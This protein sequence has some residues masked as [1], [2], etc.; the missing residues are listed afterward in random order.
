[1]TWADLKNASIEEVISWAE[2][3]PWCRS[4]AACAQDAEWHSEGDVWTHTKLVLRQL[5]ELGEWPELRPE[6]KTL[7][8][9]TALLHDVAKPLTTEID[10]ISGRV[11]S[12]KHAIKGEHVARNVLRGIG[13]DL[14]TREEI[15]RL[16][17]YHGRPAFLLERAEP[18]HEVARLSWL[19]NNRIL[20]LFALADTRGRDTDAMSR[21]EENLHLWKLTAEESGCFDRPFAF[22]G[23]HARFVFFREQSPNLHY[24]PYENHSCRVTMLSGLPGSGK[25]TWLQRNRSQLPVVSLD[26]I[27]QELGVLPKDDQGRVAQTAKARCREL[28]RAGVDFAFNATNTVR[29][30]RGRWIDLFA[31]YHARVEIV[32]LEPPMSEILRRN[33]TRKASA[34][35]AIVGKLADNCEPPT[36]A[37]CH[38]LELSG[39]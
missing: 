22:A 32:Y 24:V 33:A 27:R 16:V 38:Q 37:E 29:Q 2:G 11:V 7:L 9:F 5:C 14:S 39:E 15:A 28:L 25:D 35:T 36:W 6:E 31:D 8:V 1:M 10:S 21:P 20:Y 34:P 4:M 26:E 23:D 13:C 19:V 3:Q 30:T 12:P 18:T 17:R